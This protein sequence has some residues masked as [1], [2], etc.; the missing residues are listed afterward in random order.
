MGS[1]RLYLI[2]LHLMHYTK[3]DPQS[4]FSQLGDVILFVQA[5]LSKFHV[6]YQSHVRFCTLAEQ[7]VDNQDAFYARRC[8][9]L[10]CVPKAGVTG[11]T[12]RCPRR[13]AQDGFYILAQG[14]L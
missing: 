14:S 5:T 10:D 8:N 13:G 7:R 1:S 4:A 9:S 3:G 11:R 12:H 2:L 6:R